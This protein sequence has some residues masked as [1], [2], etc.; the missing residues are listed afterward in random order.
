MTTII[1]QTNLTSETIDAILVT[2]SYMGM[3]CESSSTGVFTKK[4][5][6]EQM[7]SFELDLKAVCS[8]LNQ[9]KEMV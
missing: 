6:C 1:N 5:M 9:M 2:L 7:K 8:K 3:K 4:F